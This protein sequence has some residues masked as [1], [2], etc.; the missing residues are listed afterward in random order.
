MSAQH[1]HDRCGRYTDNLYL[2][3]SKSVGPTRSLIKF[4]IVHILETFLTEREVALLKII[5]WTDVNHNELCIA[6]QDESY[7]F[8]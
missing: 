6:A 5:D 8:T 1:L 2:A 4:N 3:L 7:H